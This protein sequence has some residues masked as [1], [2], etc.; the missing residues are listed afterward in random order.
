VHQVKRDKAQHVLGQTGL[1]LFYPERTVTHHFDDVALCRFQ[2]Q[3]AALNG[4]VSPTN[5]QQ[6]IKE[7]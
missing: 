2:L 7:A 5:R 6:M 1:P 4:S 3:R